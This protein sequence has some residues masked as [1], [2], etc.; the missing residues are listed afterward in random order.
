MK[1]A[2]ALLEIPSTGHILAAGTSIQ[3]ILISDIIT[4]PSD[5]LPA[6]SKPHPSHFGPA[7]KSIST[8]ISQIASPQDAEVKVAILT[9]SDTV[10]SGASP[11]RRYLFK[12]SW[13]PLFFVM[14]NRNA[15]VIGP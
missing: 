10:S 11:D 12:L 1:S 5:K 4:S 8:D 15:K 13:T 6:P 9:V 3:A 2:N 7:A 14:C